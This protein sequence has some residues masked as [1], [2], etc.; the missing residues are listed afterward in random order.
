L[1]TLLYHFMKF[2]HLLTSFI[3]AR[4]LHDALLSQYLGNISSDV[5][6]KALRETTSFFEGYYSPEAF[7]GRGHILM[8]TYFLASAIIISTGQAAAVFLILRAYGTNRWSIATITIVA[9]IMGLLYREFWR[10]NKNQPGTTALVI[11][12]SASVVVLFVIF[13][14]FGRS[15]PT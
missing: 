15:T 14:I 8:T 1:A 2:G 9:G 6:F 11:A 12:S 10:S 3:E 4:R 13:W 7:G 5:K